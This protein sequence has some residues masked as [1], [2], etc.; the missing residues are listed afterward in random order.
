MNESIAD[1][2][3]MRMQSTGLAKA[4]ADSISKHRIPGMAGLIIGNTFEFLG[5]PKSSGLSYCQVGIP[6][7]SYEFLGTP[8]DCY[9]NPKFLWNS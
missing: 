9:G 7:N 6:S 4:Q 2:A 8:I 5:I 3:E 1:D